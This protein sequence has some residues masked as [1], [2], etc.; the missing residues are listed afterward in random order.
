MDKL[1]EMGVCGKAHGIKGGFSFKL[2]NSDDSIFEA[3]LKISLYPS[4]SSSSLSSRGQ[5]FEIDQISFGNKTIVY[6]K[7]ISD[8]NIVDAMIP[9]TIKVDRASFPKLEEGEFYISDLIGVSVFDAHTGNRLGEILDFYDNGAQVVLIMQ[10][11]GKKMDIL[12][13]DQFVPKVD[14]ENERVE[15]FIPE[16]VDGQ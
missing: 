3:G 4:D 16:V 14:L 5:E 1:I 8:R 2:Y 7:G 11:N 10:I 13:I 12:F 9:F 15:V 6:L